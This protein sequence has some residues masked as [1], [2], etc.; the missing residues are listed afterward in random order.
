MSEYTKG[1]LVVIY[2]LD[3]EDSSSWED[4]R[5]IDLHTPPLAKNVG[6]FLSEDDKCVRILPSIA[7]SEDELEAGRSIIPKCAI[8][9]VEKVRE[10]ELEIIVP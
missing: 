9:C 5:L 10:D 3:T 2:W 4:I 7:G 6:W 1:D 8:V